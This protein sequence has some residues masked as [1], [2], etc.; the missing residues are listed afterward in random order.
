[1][2]DREAQELVRMIESNWHFDLGEAGRK[3]WRQEIM[4]YDAELAA[5]S[6]AHLARRASY[7]ITLAD[8]SQTLEMFARNLRADELRAADAKALTEGRRG[9]ATPEWVWVWKWAR[10]VRE[11]TEDRAF[12]Q[13]RDFADPQTV[14]P[15]A[16]YDGLRD[17]W[18]AAGSPKEKIKIGRAI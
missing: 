8:L 14:M 3:M 1:M 18:L 2:N 7:K 6:L 5:K 10:Q 12:P 17:E 11:P 13:M 16:D 9:Y 4:L 15:T